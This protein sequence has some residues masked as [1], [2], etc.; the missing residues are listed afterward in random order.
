MLKH[1]HKIDA[2][3]LRLFITG[4]FVVLFSVYS[5]S[6]T[7]LELAGSSYTGVPLGLT[8]TNQTAN[9]LENTAG[10]TFLTFNPNI[11]VTASISNQQYN[12]ISTSRISTGK[13]INFGGRVN[14]IIP[15]ATQVPVFNSLNTV[16]SPSNN[17]FTSNANGPISAGIDIADNYGFYFYNSVDEL[18]TNSDAVNGRYYFGDITLTFSQPVSNPVIHINGLGCNVLFGNTNR[19]GITSELELQTGGVSLSKLSGTSEFDVTANKILNNTLTPSY[20]CGAGAACGSVKV[21]GTNITTLTFKV[22]VRGDGNGTAWSHTSINAG[23]EYMISVSINTPVNIAGNVFYDNNG[24]TD[25]TVNGTGTNVGGSLFA[26]LIDSNNKVVA[27]VAVN[28]NGT[29]QF[30]AVGDGTYN[31]ILST[32]QGTQ[33]S[34]AP[35]SVLPSGYVNTGEFVGSGVG[36]DASIDG[37]VTVVVSSSNVTN[38]NFGIFSCPTIT[39]ASANQAV[40]IGNNGNNITVNTSLNTSNGIRFVKF[41]NKQIAGVMPTATELAAIYAGT[42]ISTVTATG[43]SNPYTATYNWNSVDFPNATNAP[44]TYYVY[45]IVNPDPGTQCR[46]VQEIAITINPLPIVDAITGL[47][48]VCVNATDT[49]SNATP[50]GVWAS[51]DNSIATVNSN[52]IVTGVSAGNVTI[53]YTVTNANGCVTTVSKLI[54]SVSPAVVPTIAASGLTTACLG[55][56]LTLTSSVSAS[57]QWYKDGVAIN[58]ATAQTYTPIVSG[59]YTMIVVAGGGACNSISNSIPVV[60]NYA[61]TPSITPSDT[62]IVCVANNDKICPAVWGYSN[63]QWYKEGVLIAAPNGTSSCLYPTTAG[64]YTLT[65]QDGSG[66]WSLPST[67]VY[68]VIDTICSGYVSGGNNGGVESKSLGDVISKRL[69]GNAFNSIAE[70]NGYSNS[71]SF[72]QNSGTVVNGGTNLLLADLVP[73]KANNATKSYI[74]TPTDIV[75]FTNAIDVLSVDYTDNIGAK[76]VAFATK[77][78]GE[79]YSHTKPICDRLKEAQ[80]LNVRKVNINGYEMLTSAIKQRTGEV[81]YCFNFS[82]GSKKNRNTFSLQSNWLTD[83]YSKEDTMYNFQLWASSYNTVVDMTKDVLNK[84]SSIQTL[85]PLAN[86]AT[87]LPSVYIKSIRRERTNI[88]LVINNPTNVTSCNF[89][90]LQKSNEDALAITKL[91]NIVLKPNAINSVSIPVADSYEGNLYMSVNSIVNDLVYM[92]DGAWNIDYNTTNTTIKKFNV[93]NNGYTTDV[94]EYP[95]YRKIN[96]EATTKDYVTAY[97]L[98]KGGG[99]E[100][101]FNDYKSIKFKATAFGTNNLKITLI[102]KGIGSWENQYSYT[103]GVTNTEQDYTV[104]LSKFI[105]KNN[106]ATINLKDITAVNFTWENNKGGISNINGSLDK[107]RFSKDDLGYV[108]SLTDIDLTIYPNPN[109]GIFKVGFIAQEDKSIVLKVVEAATGINVKTQFMNAKK[110]V[111]NITVDL[112]AASIKSGVYIVKIDSDGLIYNGKKVVLNKQ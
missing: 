72:T 104:S 102:K 8:T 22:Y 45:A 49:L 26:N 41:A 36:S 56:G 85:Q 86:N 54:T 52:G 62:A 21:A 13:G 97:K 19:Q 94:N 38:V 73:T 14:S 74:T 60:I 80:L 6:Q 89:K 46:P 59:T 23:D 2:P 47:S 55:S 42:S 69:Y 79:V 64:N 92:S 99:I 76:A 108:A 87:D 81:E 110:G 107:L 96:F 39:N 112:S 93:T 5:F 61:L 20:N 24:L 44:I 95:L 78:L 31:V 11:T 67:S 101:D 9:L 27:S 109:Q 32:I 106:S 16:D 7:Q 12:N 18:F 90:V 10:S 75:N 70:I 66:C 57:Y 4:S 77:T 88:E 28:T 82:I 40:C 103:L 53:S 30:S 98:V 91:I 50:L 34:T 100:R 71:Q 1:L 15:I 51:S 29:Y 43:A 3:L 17:H 35:A 33:G 37:A 105:A 68:V 65:A 25:N 63:Y 111:N 48:T 84:V 83:N 58:G